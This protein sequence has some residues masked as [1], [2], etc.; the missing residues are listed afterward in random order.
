[1]SYK[2]MHYMKY[3]LPLRHYP[4]YYITLIFQIRGRSLFTGRGGYSFG[5]EINKNSVTPLWDLPKIYDR[6]PTWDHE[7]FYD[8][9]P[10]NVNGWIHNL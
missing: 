8:P 3:Q 4:Q 9:P 7:K 5:E 10:T 1:M 2:H 6:P